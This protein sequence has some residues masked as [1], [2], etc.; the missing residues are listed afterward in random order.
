MENHKVY[1]AN[2]PNKVCENDLEEVFAKY[3]N[4]RYIDLKRELKTAP[5]ALIAYQSADEADRAASGSN[6]CECSA[7]FAHI[8]VRPAAKNQRIRVN[9]SAA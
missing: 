3:G 7:L 4:I 9:R 8:V 6:G 1:V 5:Y 2:L